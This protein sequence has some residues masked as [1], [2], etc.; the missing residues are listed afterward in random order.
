MYKCLLIKAL[1]SS[2]KS[3]FASYSPA[4][5]ELHAPACLWLPNA[6]VKMMMSDRD[7][8]ILP[9]LASHPHS[10][11]SI[12]YR[13]KGWHM[14][15]ISHSLPLHSTL[16]P[17]PLACNCTSLLPPVSQPGTIILTVCA[18]IPRH[19]VSNCGNKNLT[20]KLT[21]LGC[22]GPCCIG[23]LR[24]FKKHTHWVECRE[25]LLLARSMWGADV[26]PVVDWRAN[27]PLKYLLLGRTPASST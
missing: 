19:P 20:T 3:M 17:H 24:V 25:Y 9:Q 5:P 27:L 14:P 26:C 1:C 23:F 18:L 21:E 6:L 8:Y 7:F 4:A 12:C 2:I 13:K 15:I 10:P 22:H 11:L 16:S